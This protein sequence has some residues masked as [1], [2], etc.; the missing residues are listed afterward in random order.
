MSTTTAVTK[1]T[2]EE[3]IAAGLARLAVLPEWL[4][5]P[6]QADRVAAALR[7]ALPELADGRLALRGCKIKRML[8]QGDTGRWAGTYTLTIEAPGAGKRTV[9]LRGTF[10][11]AHVGAVEAAV[12]DAPLGAEGWRCALPELGLELEPEP[13]ESDL[14]A[15][16]ALTDPDSSRALLEDGIRAD[17]YPDMRIESCRPEVLSY[18]PGSRCT[19]RYH[20]TYPA[21][22]AGRG[23]PATVIAKTYRKES[24]GRNAYDGMVALWHS[25]L[26]SG[27][28]VTIAEP[29]AY[30]PELKV[31]TQGPV[32][33]EQ[34][35]EDLLKD[36]LRADT[37]EAHAELNAAMARAAAGLAAFHQSGVRHGDSVTLGQRYAEIH[38]LIERLLVAAPELR[39]AAEP[40]L[41][42]LEAQEAQ[43]PADPPVPTHGTFNPEQVL[44]DGDRVGFIDF[45]D[46]CM[47][48]PALDVGLFRA[49][50]KDIGM[51]AL[52][53]TDRAAREA[54]LGQLDQIGEV[55][56]SAYERLAPISR[57]RV[58]LWEAWSY[59]RDTLHF[60]IKVKPAEPD[61]GMMMLKHHLQKNVATFERFN[62]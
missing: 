55:F 39:G 43:A 28:V 13:P 62:V 12:A 7:Q 51:N 19:I 33:G 2:T 14:Q 53:T 24:K 37:P 49:A 21:E 17:S 29:L 54:R 45:D 10:T 41:A 50:I 23:W 61:N 4:L 8:L 47:A 26:A 27:E 35:L 36:A 6:L 3:N 60:W 18:K 11:P 30:I 16:P 56:L 46:F 48:E 57:E 25:P 40:L 42:R 9:A 15:M 34:S 44:I 58:A 32:A 20:L 22:L 31:M 52:D 1:E 38:A 59:F 5:A